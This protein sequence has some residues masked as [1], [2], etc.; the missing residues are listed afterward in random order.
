GFMRMNFD[1]VLGKPHQV[2]TGVRFTVQDQS[3]SLEVQVTPIAWP[4]SDP[5]KISLKGDESSWT[6]AQAYPNVPKKPLSFYKPSNPAVQKG[7]SMP[8]VVYNSYVE[9]TVSDYE[10]D[11]SQSTIPFFDTQPVHHYDTKR[12]L[13]GVGLMHK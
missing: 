12:W 3:V 10:E 11:L 2:V 8:D 4:K 5:T 9:F 7:P 6:G 1:I 13:Q